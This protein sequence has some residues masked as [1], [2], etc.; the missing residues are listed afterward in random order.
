MMQYL[1]ADQNHAQDKKL[2]EYICDEKFENVFKLVYKAIIY[3]V[4]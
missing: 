3:K 2:S 1:E 4:E